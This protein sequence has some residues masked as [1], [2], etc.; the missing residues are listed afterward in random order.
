MR[1]SSERADFPVAVWWIF[2]GCWVVFFA[3][4]F[5]PFQARGNVL[6]PKHGKGDMCV[7][8][9]SAL[10]GRSVLHACAKGGLRACMPPLLGLEW[11]SLKAVAKN[12][13]INTSFLSFFI[14][15]RS[16]FVSL[17]LSYLHF[18]LYIHLDFP[19]PHSFFSALNSMVFRADDLPRRILDLLRTDPDSASFAGQ[20]IANVTM[21]SNRARQGSGLNGLQRYLGFFRCLTASPIYPH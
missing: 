16:F 4:C 20:D 21:L 18:Y 10:A 3:C 8:E 1:R 7:L 9:E 17:W 5:P 6:V 2:A 15:G 12:M 19:A 13:L 11:K 14:C